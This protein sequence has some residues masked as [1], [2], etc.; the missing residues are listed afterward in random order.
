MNWAWNYSGPLFVLLKFVVGAVAQTDGGIL[1]P[2]YI[3]YQNIFT[4]IYRIHLKKYFGQHLKVPTTNTSWT[5]LARHSRLDVQ[6]KIAIL[7][8]TSFI[9]RKFSDLFLYSFLS[10]HHVE[11]LFFLN[12]NLHLRKWYLE[13]W[14]KWIIFLRKWNIAFFKHWRKCNTPNKSYLGEIVWIKSDV[15]SFH[16]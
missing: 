15:T 8:S 14:R 12:F 10:M 6:E 13:K 5:F 11:R 4:S 9:N 1:I 7:L 2:G 16:F 3:C